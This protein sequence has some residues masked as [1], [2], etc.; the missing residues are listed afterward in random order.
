MVFSE[1]REGTSVGIDRSGHY[2]GDLKAFDAWMKEF[3]RLDKR[4]IDAMSR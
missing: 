4:Q 3:S 2:A 1:T